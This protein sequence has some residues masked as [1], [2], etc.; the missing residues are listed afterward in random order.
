MEKAVLYLRVS[1]KGQEDRYSLDA[2]EKKGYEYAKAHNLEIVKKWRGPESAWGKKER[3]NFNQMLDYIKKH[4]EVKHV[5]FDILDRMTRNDF[6]KMKMVELIKEYH[7]VIHFSRTNK[8]YD[9]YSGPDEEFM[10]DIEIAVAKKM[11]NDIARK[12]KMGMQEKA[13][14][15][16]YPTNTPLGYLNVKNGIAVDPVN[17]PL[18]QTLFEKVASGAYSLIALEDEMYNLG[19][20]HKTRKSKVRKSTLY[21]ILKNPFYYGVFGW[22]K[23]EYQGT[24]QPLVSKELWLKAGAKLS[25]NHKP[26]ASK[27]DFAFKGLLRCGHCGCTV[28]GEVAKGKYTYY[29]CSFSKGNHKH[30]GYLPEQA[31]ADK[32]TQIVD[33]ITIPAEISDWLKDG[34]AQIAQTAESV[35]KNQRAVLTEEYRKAQGKLSKL[36]DLRLEGR[37]NQSVLDQKEQ[38]LNEEISHLEQQLK[39]C[40]CEE[41]QVVQRTNETL[42]MIKHLG[43]LFRKADNYDKAKILRLLGESFILDAANNIK[44]QYRMPFNFIA[45]AR[46]KEL[47][48]KTGTVPTELLQNKT[49][50]LKSSRDLIWGG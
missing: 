31:L 6:D 20:R 37:L 43:I 28:L 8:V 4:S 24:H 46:E 14:Q 33:Q 35:K 17:G 7:K 48:L 42:E 11:S 19:L 13:E 9:E 3:R 47:R 30:A 38:E 1:S 5:I 44:T 12:T 25:S 10:W 41:K 29:R 23:K 26:Y 18:I 50:E 45:E 16:I 27:R 15:G 34:I 22:G 32:F 21:R 49:P 2:Q 40:G 36:Y 39:T